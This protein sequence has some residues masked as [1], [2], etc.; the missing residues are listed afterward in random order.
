LLLNN[1]QNSLETNPC[2]PIDVL[3]LP[4]SK[5]TNLDV[6]QRCESILKMHETTKLNIEKMNE[7]YRV[8]CSKVRKEVK[9]EPDDLVWVHLR[10]D[11]FSDF[12]KSG[13]LDRV[14]CNS[15]YKFGIHSFLRLQVLQLKSTRVHL[16]RVQALFTNKLVFLKEMDKA[17]GWLG[18]F[19]P[20]G[21]RDRGKAD[22][23]LGSLVPV[24]EQAASALLGLTGKKK[25][26]RVRVRDHG[27][28]HHGHGRGGDSGQ[29]GRRSHVLDGGCLL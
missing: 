7:K 10:K 9:L 21:R 1:V 2:T 25:G 29:A 6:A 16:R 23:S 11:Q 28:H 19:L 27:H 26:R 15:F 8:A 24:P 14:H 17:G 22:K 4:P 13:P 18:H 3:P 20:G 5:I 12:R